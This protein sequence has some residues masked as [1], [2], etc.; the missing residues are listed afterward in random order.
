MLTR[1]FDSVNDL[2]HDALRALVA[3]NAEALRLVRVGLSRRCAVPTE[4]T[5]ANLAAGSA[6]LIGLKTLA[7]VLSAEGRL[8]EMEN[9]PADAARSY[10]DAIRLGA[11]MSHRGVMMNRLVGIACEGVGCIPLVKL[12]PKLTCDEMRPLI[13]QLEVID[14]NAV[15]WAEVVR[16]ENRFVRTQA[17]TYPNPIK[18]VQ[19]LWQSRTIRKASQERHE[20]AVVHLRLLATEMALRCYLCDHANAPGSLEQLVQCPLNPLKYNRPF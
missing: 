1:R 2:D 5:I 19:D 10:L 3:T 16:N 11:Q 7:R 17:G 13:T 9:R 15:T 14:T 18:L 12:L 20:L 4:L 6:D 8:A